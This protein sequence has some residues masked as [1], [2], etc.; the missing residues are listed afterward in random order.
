MTMTSPR[1]RLAVFVLC[2]SVMATVRGLD[3]VIEHTKYTAH[4]QLTEAGRE[5]SLYGNQ[6][7]Y[8]LLALLYQTYGKH[9]IR[10][11]TQLVSQM[12]QFLAELDHVLTDG[13]TNLSKTVNT[14]LDRLNQLVDHVL[15]TELFD[16]PATSMTRQVDDVIAEGKRGADED[17]V[18]LLQSILHIMGEYFKGYST[19][20]TSVVGRSLRKNKGIPEIFNDMT[21]VAKNTFNI[22]DKETRKIL[23]DLNVI[24]TA[25]KQSLSEAYGIM[26]SITPYLD[27][28]LIRRILKNIFKRHVSIQV[29]SSF[30][31]KPYAYPARRSRFVDGK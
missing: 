29:V 4:A 14:T 23:E 10:R 19:D 11:D 22:V 18:I 8:E 21:Q 15:H 30:A 28:T 20:D 31:G 1:H 3:V 5:A 25:L 6:A 12:G 13:V 26:E 17:G 16:T 27:Q 24:G 2:L 7:C 9:Y